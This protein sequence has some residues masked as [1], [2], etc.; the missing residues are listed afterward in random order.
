[1]IGAT[2]W[3]N[4]P[5]LHL[6]REKDRN[7]RGKIISI[8]PK[9]RAQEERE[10][11]VECPE[12]QDVKYWFNDR[13]IVAKGCFDL[14]LRFRRCPHGIQRF[15][16]GKLRETN[17]GDS[18]SNLIFDIYLSVL[19]EYSRISAESYFAQPGTKCMLNHTRS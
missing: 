4:N 13:N 8:G 7:S 16:C 5:R 14:I 12:S 19:S 10:E 15:K 2:E 18:M 6:H 3:Y 17:S 1:M 11:F 9:V